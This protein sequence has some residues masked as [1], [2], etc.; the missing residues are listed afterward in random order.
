MLF[1]RHSKFEEINKYI[2]HSY[3]VTQQHDVFHLKK[4]KKELCWTTSF[5]EDILI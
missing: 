3:V 4:V 1:F 5:T 2:K